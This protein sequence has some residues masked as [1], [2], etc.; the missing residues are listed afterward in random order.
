[1]IRPSSAT[2]GTAVAA[3]TPYDAPVTN[4]VGRA[5]SPKPSAFEQEV[6]RER[7]EWPDRAQGVAQAGLIALRQA[8]DRHAVRC[9]RAVL[10]ILDLLRDDEVEKDLLRFGQR[11]EFA[12]AADAERLE[13]G[14]PR[15]RRALHHVMTDGERPRRG[16]DPE[17]AGFLEIDAALVGLE[18]AEET[19]PRL[20]RARRFD[21][22]L[23]EAGLAARGLEGVL[24]NRAG[25]SHVAVHAAKVKE[26]IDR[27]QILRVRAP[28]PSPDA[29][30]P[31]AKT[32][33]D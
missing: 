22:G 29:V 3:P 13:A 25:E 30:M 7:I 20:D 5:T 17:Q 15:R 16:D 24:P 9:R 33:S 27:Q 1:M 12:F 19:E 21:E 28:N 23:G 8:F 26:D 32:A 4:A 2:F 18:S 14:E 11:I 10:D 31:R 6:A